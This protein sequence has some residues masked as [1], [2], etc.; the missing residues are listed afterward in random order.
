MDEWQTY[1]IRQ[2]KFIVAFATAI[3]KFC[4]FYNCTKTET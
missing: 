2:V 3:K 4:A 1:A